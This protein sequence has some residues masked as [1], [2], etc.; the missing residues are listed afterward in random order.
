[1]VKQV[2]ACLSDENDF[3]DIAPMQNSALSN[4]ERIAGEAKRQIDK[5]SDY[6]LP[7]CHRSSSADY[8]DKWYLHQGKKTTGFVEI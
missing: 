4:V 8:Y 5:M 1:M 2:T 7:R 3:V 6:Q